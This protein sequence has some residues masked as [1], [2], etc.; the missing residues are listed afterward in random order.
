MELVENNTMQECIDGVM[1]WSYCRGWCWWKMATA[2]LG[3]AKMLNGA[4]G[5]RCELQKENALINI[6]KT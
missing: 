5:D 1:Q 4:E 6:Y 2:D 3:G